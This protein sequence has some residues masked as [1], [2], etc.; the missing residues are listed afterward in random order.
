MAYT[1]DIE[2]FR[3]G[4]EYRAAFAGKRVLITGSGK[5]GGIGRRPSGR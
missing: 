3:F 4:D 2:Q 5:D 1:A